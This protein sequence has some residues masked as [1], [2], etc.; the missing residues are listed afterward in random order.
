M[1]D[2]IQ[3]G[4]CPHHCK[5]K[6][7]QSGFCKARSCI[8]G[9]VVSLT[10]GEM[11][12]FH[13]DPIEKKPL[14]HFYPGSRIF[15]AGGFGCNLRCFFCQNHEISQH[16]SHG[17][18]VTPQQMAA[19]SAENDSLGICFTYS[20]PLVWY[21]ML[22]ETAPLVKKQ[23]GKVVLVS[24]GIIEEEYLNN[25]LPYLDAANIDIKGFS[26]EFYHQHTG[27]KLEWVLKTVEK[28]AAKVHTEITTLVI[29]T[30]N[31]S[32][33]EITALARWLAQLDMPIAWHLSR[34]YPMYKSNIPAT[35][36]GHLRVLWDQVKDIL[37]YVYLGNMPGGNT[38]CCPKC[39]R[40]V[41]RRDNGIRMETKD[42]KCPDCGQLIWGQ[43]LR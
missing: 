19:M 15:S 43:G 42:S 8:G 30:L 6:E 33:E 10:Y 1:A 23:G 12:A 2:F 17:Q 5:L 40:D 11:A 37:P 38:T 32:P 18:Y 39:G 35:D 29:P 27:G 20:E 16:V 34:Y 13:L 7:G 21:E 28:L 3:C 22:M 14:Y 41:I 31:D 24:N 26:E 9:K 4:L 25:L 36:M